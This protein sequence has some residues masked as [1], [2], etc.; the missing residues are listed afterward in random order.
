MPVNINDVIIISYGNLG[1]T[2]RDCHL[3]VTARLTVNRVVQ[4]L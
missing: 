4:N 2:V 3:T 1:R